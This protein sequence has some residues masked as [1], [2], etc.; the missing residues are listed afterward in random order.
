MALTL[1]I[2]LTL[3]LGAPRCGEPCGVAAGGGRILTL[4]LTLPLTL[5]LT[6]TLTLALAL[7][8]AL[9]LALA[10]A[11]TLTLTRRGRRGPWQRSPGAALPTLLRALALPGWPRRLQPYPYPSPYPYAYPYP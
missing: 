6:L 1:I 9:T 7:A 11:L 10:L 4:T 8:L 3:T 2:A 5:T